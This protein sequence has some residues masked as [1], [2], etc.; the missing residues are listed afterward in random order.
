MSLFPSLNTQVCHLL[1]SAPE[2]QC[3]IA[4]CDRFERVFVAQ[5]LSE[6]V[7]KNECVI[8]GFDVPVVVVL[9][10]VDIFVGCKYLA[11]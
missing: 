7:D 8:V 10:Q 2:P 9:I 3:H 1:L 11:C 4:V 6:I 5:E